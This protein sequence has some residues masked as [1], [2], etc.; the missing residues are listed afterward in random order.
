MAK[1]KNEAPYDKGA[2]RD[3]GTA[4]CKIRRPQEGGVIP[5]LT[6]DLQGLERAIR[7][8]NRENRERIEKFWGLNGGTNFSKKPIGSKDIALENMQRNALLA[9]RE[10]FSMDYMFLYDMKFQKLI[11]DIGKKV[12]KPEGV[13]DFMACKWIL[14]YCIFFCNGPKMLY[15]PDLSE[16]DNADEH[17]VFDDYA[18]LE[19]FWARTKNLP[20][21][22]ISFELMEHIMTMLDIKDR[23]AIKKSLSIE[24][25]KEEQGD[26][27]E[28][29][30]IL[31]TFAEIRKFK[32]EMFPLGPWLVTESIILG[33]HKMGNPEEFRTFMEELNKIW[34]SNWNVEPYKTDD[35]IRV[36][37][38]HGERV[39]PV[40]MIA[41][42]AITDVTELMVLH[43]A[44]RIMEG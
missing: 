29:T 32:E 23:R 20:E 37:T 30:R 16:L 33:G 8:I 42:Q 18:I 5:R 4:M 34:L 2:L 39:L 10:I 12:K 26:K 17:L 35:T 14:A 13:D 41:N 31:K 11:E 22:S 38:S 25:E 21:G 6:I 36:R 27:F 24:V 44:A 9:I 43:L 19:N 1:K 40:Y 7:S 28:E 15:E 3:L